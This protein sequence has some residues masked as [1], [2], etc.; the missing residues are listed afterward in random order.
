MMLLLL[1]FISLFIPECAAV[2]PSY[3]VQDAL[4][5][6]FA[7]I[8]PE[9]TFKCL[10]SNISIIGN[11]VNDDY[12]DCPDGSD[13]P[14]TSACTSRQMKVKFPSNWNFRCKNEGFKFQEIPHTR[15]NDGICD[16]CDG[17]DEYSGAK[18]CPNICAEFQEK[19]EKRILEAERIRSAGI[20]EKKKMS[21]KAKEIREKDK[22]KLEKSLPE[23]ERLNKS[24]EEISSK[25]LPLEE[26]ENEE[27]KRLREEYD[28]AFE[29]WKKEKE[30]K[31]K[32]NSTSN[33]SFSCIR[34]HTKED[35]ETENVLEEDKGCDELISE[36]SGFCEC[37][38]NVTNSSLVF[39]R[40]CDYPPFSCSSVCEK[41]GGDD[42]IIDDEDFKMDDGSTFE[43]PEARELRTELK[44]SREKLNELSLTV[45]TLKDRLSR[46][47]T[48][49]DL[50]RTLEGECFTIDFV[51]YTYEMCPFRDVHQY[52]KGTKSGPSLGRWGRF[53]ENTYS[54]W[55]STSDYTHMIFDNG[56]RCWNGATRSTDV[57]LVCGPENKLTPAEEP[58]MCKYSMVFQ[59]PAV[60]E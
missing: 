44:E 30:A 10:N 56:D 19:E 51:S 58:S 11:Q 14:G 27:K 15:V 23:V 53:G 20:L 8:K 42:E 7:S 31:P 40:G 3:G 52:D 29:K 24:V 26:K 13:E 41:G 32:E 21:E 5:E 28:I 60:C 43:L 2:P 1:F 50:I 17:S 25:L 59:T 34:W 33:S 57:H 36:V 55:S 54:V 47:I 39:E 37:F 6:K 9:D 38:N 18:D 4:L 49:E 22:V 35:C 46:N 16:C 12:C 45:K 48:T